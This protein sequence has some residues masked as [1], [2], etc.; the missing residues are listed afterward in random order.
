MSLANDHQG[1]RFVLVHHYNE[2][3]FSRGR[4]VIYFLFVHYG[5]YGLRAMG[6]NT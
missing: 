2:C 1:G 3:D 4:G 5:E 6:T